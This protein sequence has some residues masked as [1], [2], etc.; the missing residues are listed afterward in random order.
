LNS[1]TNI[2]LIR[3]PEGIVFSQWLAGPVTRFLAWLVDLLCISAVASVL[4]MAAALLGFLSMGLAQAVSILLYFALSLGYGMVLEWFWR[5]QTVGKRML[6]LRVVDAQGFRLHFSQI[7]IRNLLRAVDMLP[8]P[9]L[10]GG[11]ACLLSRRAQRLGDFAAN[12]VVI[13][14]PKLAEPD[15]DQ[16]LAGRYNS[17]RDYPHLAARLRQ[18]VSPQEAGLA[19]QAILR[20]DLL[21]PQSRVEL[22][23]QIAERF[24]SKVTFPAETVG[25]LADEQYVRNVVDVLYRTSR[26][27]ASPGRQEGS[28]QG[29]G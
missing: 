14:S 7:A 20:R 2:L 29:G 28:R 23:A 11:V 6:R 16:L 27:G 5:G 12:T 9:Y 18:R 4:G 3:T 26:T 25:G 19:M 15:L 21:D 17:L 1:K 24:R 22:F 10:L 8:G 13:R